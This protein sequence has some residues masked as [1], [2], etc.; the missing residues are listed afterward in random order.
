M[1]CSFLLQYFPQNIIPFSFSVLPSIVSYKSYEK[2][3]V[4]F[5]KTALLKVEQL[6]PNNFQVF[7]N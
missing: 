7:L 6:G 2:Y 3:T 5:I 4:P 1:P